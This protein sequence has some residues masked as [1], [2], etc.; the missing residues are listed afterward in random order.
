MVKV[1]LHDTTNFTLMTTS[2]YM[3][4]DPVTFAV[5]VLRASTP[6]L[7]IPTVSFSCDYGVRN[8]SATYLYNVGYIHTQRNITTVNSFTKSA[9]LV[10]LV[11]HC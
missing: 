10:T 8:D 2:I 11:L 4:I 9:L 1:M 3:R 6:E 5:Q 7:A